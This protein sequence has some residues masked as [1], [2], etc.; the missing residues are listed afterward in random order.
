MKHSTTQPQRSKSTSTRTSAESGQTQRIITFKLTRRPAS[1]CESSAKRHWQRLSTRKKR[2][3]KKKFSQSA[4]QPNEANRTTSNRKSNHWSSSTTFSPPSSHRTSNRRTSLTW[5]WTAS[6]RRQTQLRISSSSN[7][8]S[9]VRSYTWTIK[10]QLIFCFQNMSKLEPAS[11]SPQSSTNQVSG[12]N[13]RP[14][15]H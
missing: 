12:T 2:N 5:T 7:R 6:R 3:W 8:P 15:P 4:S 11:S 1:A 9:H 14:F 13:L 10:K